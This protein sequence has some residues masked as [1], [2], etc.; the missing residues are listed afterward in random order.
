M[1]AAGV[2]DPATLGPESA[3]VQPSTRM[4]CLA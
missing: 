4:T 1:S 3:A 2:L